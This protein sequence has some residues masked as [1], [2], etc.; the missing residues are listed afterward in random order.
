MGTIT[1]ELE[2]SYAATAGAGA[3]KARLDGKLGVPPREQRWFAFAGDSKGKGRRLGGGGRGGAADGSWYGGRFLRRRTGGGMQVFVRTLGGRSLA[4]DVS[5]SDTVDAVKAW[6]QARE[7]VAAADQRLVFAGRE[8]G[9][10]RRTLAEYGVG[11]EANLFLHRRLRGGAGGGAGAAGS[12]RATTAAAGVLAAVVAIGAALAYFSV[13]AAAAAAAAG[14][15]GMTLSLA[16]LLLAW[17]LAMAGVNLITAG[18][19]LAGRA[20][21]VRCAVQSAVVGKASAFVRRNLAVV[22]VAAASSAATGVIFGGGDRTLCFVSFALF[23]VAM[24]LV[25]IG[26]ANCAR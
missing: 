26:V 9:D 18:V 14:A 12:R 15:S 6:V 20:E 5:P 21:T 8:L 10:G 24:S 17:A 22:G 23:L 3:G 25:T 13:P 4:L 7:R 16:V 1:C 19:F 11:K 2:S